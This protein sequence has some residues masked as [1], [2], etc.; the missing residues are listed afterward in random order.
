MD[1]YEMHEIT[2]EFIDA[3]SGMIL[4]YK[5]YKWLK[6]YIEELE[7]MKKELKEEFDEEEERLA[8]KNKREREAEINDFWKSQFP[9]FPNF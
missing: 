5:R 2:D 1:E 8:E 7:G 9:N 6:D 3:L 4:E